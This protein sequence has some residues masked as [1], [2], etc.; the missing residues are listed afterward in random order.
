MDESKVRY[1][2]DTLK[3]SQ[4]KDPNPRSQFQ[5]ENKT[6]MK[7]TSNTQMTGEED[8]DLVGLDPVGLETACSYRAPERIVLQQVT[9]LEKVIIK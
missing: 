5:E 1:S 7:D 4:G 2:H 9:L 8:M 6:I 3:P